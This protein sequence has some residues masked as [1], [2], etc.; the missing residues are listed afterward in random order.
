MLAPWGGLPPAISA[1]AFF[2]GELVQAFR[3]RRGAKLVDVRAEVVFRA[4]FFGAIL[5]WPI[6]RAV[7]PAARIGGGTWPCTLGIVLGWLGLLL[8]W[9]SF[10]SLGRYFTVTVRT[11]ADQ[12]VVDHGPYRVLRHPSY[13]GLLLV[14]A[15]GGLV[16]GN[17]VG[18]AGAVAVL[19]LALIHRLRIEERALGDALGDR[20]RQ[21]AASRA[22]LVPYV[23]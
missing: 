5:L 22:R 1:G 4:L 15:G 16:V 14:F 2:A 17:W 18:A 9:W 10:A 13:T 12:P 23:W 11:S 20:Y 7:V 6:G 3:T 21:F 8:R 19:L